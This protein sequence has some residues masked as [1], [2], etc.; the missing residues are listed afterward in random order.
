MYVGG[1]VGIDSQAVLILILFIAGL[2]VDPGLSFFEA[3]FFVSG[4]R[5]VKNQSFPAAVRHI[6]GYSEIGQVGKDGVIPD[7][8]GV[9]GGQARLRPLMGCI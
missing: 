6:V 3:F 2:E 7:F 1:T 8:Y 9:V 4:K 5:G